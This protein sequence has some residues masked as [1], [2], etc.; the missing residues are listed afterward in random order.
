TQQLDDLLMREA[1]KPPA[2]RNA[3]SESQ[4]RDE[5]GTKS[6]DIAVLDAR[7]EREFPKY[8]ELIS[9]QPLALDAARKLLAEDEALLVFLV[10]SR[11]SFIWVARREDV[12]FERLAITGPELET[13]VRKLRT[14][15]DLGASDAARIL[16][17]PFDTA[18]AYELYR[19]LLS[20]AEKILTGVRH[21]IL[22][23]DGALQS[24]PLG[25]LVTEPPARPPTGFG[26][27]SAIPWLAKKYAMTVLPAVS[28]LRALRAFARTPPGTQP[29]AGFGDPVLAGRGGEARGASLK[30][31][32]ARG[33][34][35]D[36]S[37][38][39]SLDR[40][41]ETA[42][43]LRAIAKTL[44]S[45]SDVLSLGAQA[46]ETRVKNMDLSQV[47]N[48]A[49]ATHGLMS[50]ELKGFAEPALVMTPPAN[51][52]E[53]DD[54]LLTASEISQL[55]LNA[56]WVILSACNT[57]AAD[58]TPGAEGLSGLAKAFF[59]AGARSLLVSH[60]S[61]SS[62]ASVA[63]TTR[64]FEEADK[65]ASKAE[66]LRRSILALMNTRDKPIMAHPA[67]WAPFIV[68]GE[69]N[70]RWNQEG[71]AVARQ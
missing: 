31:M 1:S 41:P 57:A 24:L 16:S 13:L 25:V 11:E 40:L 64:M 48:L 58:G 19:R 27:Y 42:D 63:L 29:F 62:E 47:R 12:L 65:G 35:A 66:A 17:R 49:F 3:K 32:F 8:R 67:F 20:P 55:K 9:P 2:R 43:E 39:R 26:Q 60:W 44:G 61:V 50:G 23:P 54:G 7:L 37:E 36:V 30:A 4:L 53:Q 15:L 18:T 71:G 68:V 14:Q 56:D 33:A 46:T 34:V 59:Y 6:R 38:V 70:E 51:G 21:L 10:T 45:G 28:S 52:T 22:V 69:G 5:Q